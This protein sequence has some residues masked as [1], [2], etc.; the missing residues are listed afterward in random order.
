MNFQEL[1]NECKTLA[2]DYDWTLSF[3][4]PRDPQREVEKRSVIYELQKVPILRLILEV[5][6]DRISGVTGSS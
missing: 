2:N 5:W 4:M 1:T 3:K 6:A